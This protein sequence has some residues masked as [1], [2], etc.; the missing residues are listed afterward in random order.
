[1]SAAYLS[2]QKDTVFACRLQRFPKFPA[3]EGDGGVVAPLE[4]PLCASVVQS[5]PELVA[6]RCTQ[7]QFQHPDPPFFLLQVT[8]RLICIS[9]LTGTDYENSGGSLRFITYF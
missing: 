6:G 2:S 3:G 7:S 8:I 9:Y 5:D 4:Q 1:M